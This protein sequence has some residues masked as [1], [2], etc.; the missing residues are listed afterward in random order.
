MDRL[1]VKASSRARLTDSVETALKLA[2]GRMTAS[3]SI[4]PRAIR[5]ASPATAN[6]WTARTAIRWR[7]ASSS[8]GRSRSTRRSARA[9]SATAWAPAARWTRTWSSRTGAC[10]WHG[11]RSR[12]G[13]AGRNASTSSGCCGR[14]RRGR[15]RH[16]H[17]V[18][19]ADGRGAAGGAA[20]YRRPGAHQLPDAGRAGNGRT[21]SFRGRIA[22]A[23]AALRR[24]GADG[25]RERY[26][27]F[28]REVPCPACGGA[29]LRPEVLAVTVGGRSIADVAAL[30]VRRGGRWLRALPDAARAADRRA[31]AGRDPGAA[32]LPGRRRPGLPVAGPAG[33]DAGRRR[34]AA[35][36]AGDPDRLRPGRGAVRAG[37]AVDRPAP[38][39]QPAADRDAA[40]AA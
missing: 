18:G 5:T 7:S 4:C 6:V 39:R 1:T 3:S 19:R 22:L 17:P 12:R 11:E 27:G 29:R 13:R 25:A 14:G 23:R 20:R 33:R 26:E 15:V 36:P 2:D 10:R 40:A 37:R 28:M 24:G 31:G 9:R 38:A 35:D 8:R 32:G 34:G 21:G 30:P 16:G